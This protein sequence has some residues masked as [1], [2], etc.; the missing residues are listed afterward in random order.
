MKHIK[1]FNESMSMKIL[2]FMKTL[3]TD[4]MLQQFKDDNKHYYV[5]KNTLPLRISDVEKMVESSSKS[6][7]LKIKF[8]IPWEVVEHDDSWDQDHD[9]R[10]WTERYVIKVDGKFYELCFDYYGQGDF[11]EEVT[12]YNEVK[13]VKPR[14]ITKIVYE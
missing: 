9:H 1:P 5:G 4:E 2:D 11:N 14:T 12:S 8:P 3:I 13:E 7:Y 10:S 6:S